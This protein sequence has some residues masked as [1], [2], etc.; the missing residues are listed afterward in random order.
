LVSPSVK[1]SEGV[2]YFLIFEKETYFYDQLSKNSL[3]DHCTR[4]SASLETMGLEENNHSN[5][6]S[7]YPS[8]S[9]FAIRPV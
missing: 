8:A 9:S 7:F 2:L 1:S 6:M 5:L 4:E 3:N